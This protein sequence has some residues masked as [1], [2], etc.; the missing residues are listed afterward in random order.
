MQSVQCD[1]TGYDNSVVTRRD[2][3]HKNFTELLSFPFSSAGCRFFYTM[4]L[5]QCETELTESPETDQ[6][7]NNSEYKREK[8]ESRDGMKE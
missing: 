1:L 2:T 8:R 4:C 3:D 7:T 5:L 6:K